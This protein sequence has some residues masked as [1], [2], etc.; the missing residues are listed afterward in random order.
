METKAIKDM[1]YRELVFERE[2]LSNAIKNT[3]SKYLKK[4]YSKAIKKID[5]VL[6]NCKQLIKNL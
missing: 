3:K 2:R 5:L 1:S 4:D 6:S